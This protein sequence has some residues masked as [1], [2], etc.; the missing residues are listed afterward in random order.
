MGSLGAGPTSQSTAAQ[1]IV[2]VDT[3]PVRL[4]ADGQLQIRL[5][6]RPWEPFEGAWA[7]PGVMLRGNER[8]TE[9]AIRALVGK[10]GVGP[11]QELALRQCGA[12][13][14]LARDPRGPTV[15]LAQLAIL[16]P[17]TPAAASEGEVMDAPAHRLPL[18]AF[19][20]QR[21]VDAA[22]VRLSEILLADAAASRSLLGAEFA[23]T[24]ANQAYAAL[25]AAGAPGASPSGMSRR[26]AATH[27]LIKTERTQ[28]FGRGKPAPVWAWHL[29]KEN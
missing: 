5:V 27:H 21:I 18:L 8:L 10:A 3:V 29:P 20:H 25:E 1:P 2:S 23:T 17:L 14:D 11:E 24:R 12:F 26:L 28:T 7:L 22:L 15:A 4:D 13:D 19:D 16:P 6:R 9:A